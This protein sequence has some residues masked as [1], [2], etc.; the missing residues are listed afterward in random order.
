MQIRLIR[1]LCH[2]RSSPTPEINKAWFFP[3]P[4]KGSA[5]VNTSDIAAE[6]F[7]SLRLYFDTG[8]TYFH[9]LFKMHLAN[10]SRTRLGSQERG[11]GRL[12]KRAAAGPGSCRTWCV[13][14]S[15]R[16]PRGLVLLRLV[17]LSLSVVD[18]TWRALR[19]SPT[20]GWAGAA[21]SNCFTDKLFKHPQ[22]QFLIYKVSIK[23]WNQ[24][25][26][27]ELLLL[28]LEKIMHTK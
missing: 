25:L 6:L 1:C 13:G 4:R 22:S 7:S 11:G 14:E 23:I 19:L 10:V 12:G 18:W 9:C 5:E 27:L 17:F 28:V 24:D 15:R 2:T 16:L 26:S 21:R 20:C 8:G 3:L